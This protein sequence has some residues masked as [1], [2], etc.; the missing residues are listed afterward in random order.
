MEHCL[1]RQ[2]IIEF[3]KHSTDIRRTAAFDA[4]ASLVWIKIWTS[5]TRSRTEISDF[6]KYRG[7]VLFRRERD[8][9][10]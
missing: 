4:E 7:S 9:D 5:V 8:L 6:Q 2:T 10:H 1:V 3:P